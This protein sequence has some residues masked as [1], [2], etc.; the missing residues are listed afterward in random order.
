MTQA[1]GLIF[2]VSRS[3]PAGRRV[4]NTKMKRRV[5]KC[6]FINLHHHVFPRRPSPV[7]ICKSSAYRAVKCN[8][9]QC[10]SAPRWQITILHCLRKSN[11]QISSRC[12]AGG[13]PQWL[14]STS[15]FLLLLSSAFPPAFISAGRKKINWVRKKFSKLIR[16]VGLSLLGA[17]MLTSASFRRRKHPAVAFVK[18]SRLRQILTPS[19][20]VA[21]RGASRQRVR[22]RA[23]REG[24]VFWRG[25]CFW[26]GVST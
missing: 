18:R 14:F 25:N 20:L 4:K 8:M 12:H 19:S 15:F 3:S 17:H 26:E 7:C 16:A 23:R 24:S 5:V 9:V 11:A 22:W 21:R 10:S 6:K 2:L 13:Q 1:V